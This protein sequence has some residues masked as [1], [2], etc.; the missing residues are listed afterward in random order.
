MQLAV[1]EDMAN[2]RFS[3]FFNIKCMKYKVKKEKT[4]DS[5]P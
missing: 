5:K 4:L 1:S 3:A 2:C